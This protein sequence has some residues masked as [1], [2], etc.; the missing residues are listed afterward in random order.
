VVPSVCIKDYEDG[1]A[2][3]L[4][5]T[6]LLE[7]RKILLHLR[8]QKHKLEKLVQAKPA[9][10]IIAEQEKQLAAGHAPV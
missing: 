4:G 7:D 9:A 10:L 3:M 8:I 1:K 5:V 2:Q 6:K